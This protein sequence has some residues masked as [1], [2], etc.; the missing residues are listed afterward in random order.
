MEQKAYNEVV[1]PEEI[2]VELADIKTME[3]DAFEIITL[4]FSANISDIFRDWLSTNTK[5]KM[6]AL[7]DAMG[8]EG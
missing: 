3:N 2:L 5:T 1:V 7:L 6:H 8:F 4:L